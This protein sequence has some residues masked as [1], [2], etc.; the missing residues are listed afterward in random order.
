MEKLS[1]LCI[2]MMSLAF[3]FFSLAI[4]TGIY[5][6]PTFSAIFTVCSFIM[7]YGALSLPD[8]EKYDKIYTRNEKG[9]WINKLGQEQG[10]IFY[11]KYIKNK[12]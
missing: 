12:Y 9:Y 5:D 11:E 10:H 4:V 1:L 7:G 8:H 6:S 2:K 3:I